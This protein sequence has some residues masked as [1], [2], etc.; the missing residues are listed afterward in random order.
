MPKST[1]DNLL[2][3]F[4][5]KGSEKTKKP[6]LKPNFIDGFIYATD[7]NIICRVA[8]EKLTKKYGS[9]LSNERT[10]E[11]SVFFKN[12]FNEKGI[13]LNREVLVDLMLR[14]FDIENCTTAIEING[15][16]FSEM[17]IVKLTTLSHEINAP[18]E[19]FV[20]DARKPNFFKVGDFEI[21]LIPVKSQ[22]IDHKFT[23]TEPPFENKIIYLELEDWQG[24]YVNGKLYD[25]RHE[26]G[27]GD[28]FYF[29]E[30]AEK[31][32]VKRKDILQLEAPIELC[33][34]VS[35]SGSL[36]NDFIEIANCFVTEIGGV[37]KEYFT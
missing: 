36:V 14:A 7:T 17:Y 24:V 23:Y 30:L 27:E 34:E 18:I 4:L 25:E 2:T 32:D 12:A 21:G 29:L 1:N 5:Y 9:V 15:I 10:L 3:A 8:S 13:I 6:F 11:F 31:F 19:F 33:V 35:K 37:P 20:T 16:C 26:I 22:E 28:K